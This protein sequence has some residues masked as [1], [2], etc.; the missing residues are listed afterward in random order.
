M[1]VHVCR[2]PKSI[3]MCIYIYIHMYLYMYIYIY[4]YVYILCHLDVSVCTL[5]YVF[6]TWMGWVDDA[7]V[8]Y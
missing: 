8:L 1:C 2:E 5:L 4:I 3:Q 7:G 6:L